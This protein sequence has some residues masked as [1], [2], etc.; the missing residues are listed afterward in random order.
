[1]R[2]FF[3]LLFGIIV[4]YG[5]NTILTPVYIEN[6]NLCYKKA[7]NLFYKIWLCVLLVFLPVAYVLLVIFVGLG[8]QLIPNIVSYLV[9]FE[10]F[11]GWTLIISSGRYKSVSNIAPFITIFLS[12]AD[13]FTYWTAT[14]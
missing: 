6:R 4:A 13:I 1:M 11:L 7:Q 14:G 10:I 2:L 9:M 3:N 5:L 8:K 12:A